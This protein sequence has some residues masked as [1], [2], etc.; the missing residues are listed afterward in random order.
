MSVAEPGSLYDLAIGQISST[1]GA[2]GGA[3]GSGASRKQWVTYLNA[4][5]RQQAKAE[6]LPAERLQE[7]FALAEGMDAAGDG[8]LKSMVNIMAQRFKALE[9]KTLG[10]KELAGSMGLVDGGDQGL[11]SKAERLAASRLQLTDLKLRESQAKLRGGR[12]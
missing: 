10:Q 8:G 11:A 6:D 9:Q 4:I 5:V 12:G 2:R 3:K 1:L 7:L